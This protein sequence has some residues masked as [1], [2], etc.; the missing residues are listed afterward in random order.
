M[1]LGILSFAHVH[2][3][4][5]A[6]QVKDLPQVTLTGIYDQSEYRGKQAASRFGT[7]YYSQ[8]R[9]LLTN[10]NGVII[11]SENALHTDLAIQAAR[12]GNHILCE[13]PIATLL[14]DADMMIKACQQNGVSLYIAFPMRF[15]P[16]INSAREYVQNGE[17]GKLLG[18]SST[19]HG[20]L[21]PGWFQNSKLAGGGAVMDHT[22]HLIDLFRWIFNQEVK[23]VYAQIGILLNDIPVEDCGLLSISFEDDSFATLDCSWSRPE[24]FGTWGDLKMRIYGTEGVI[25]L[26]SF[27]QQFTSFSDQRMSPRFEYWGTNSDQEMIKEFVKMIRGVT[28]E[29]R[30]ATGEDGKKCLQVA[31][32]AY[33]S[34]KKNA[35]VNI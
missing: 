9:A 13:K 15:S 4:N 26:D 5:Y 6:T 35:P 10:T 1:K 24:S 25:D 20:K 27:M 3:P 21:P 22:P 19:N 18:I 33:Q 34:T 7:E 14:K 16:P 11:C 29:T 28:K 12:A 23:E 31:L 32:A 2:A 8:P 17:V 30:L